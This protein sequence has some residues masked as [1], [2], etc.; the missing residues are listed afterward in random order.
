MGFVGAE[1]HSLHSEVVSGHPAVIDV[2]N[3]LVV[4]DGCADNLEKSRP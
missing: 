3:D 2:Q 1:G 4:I